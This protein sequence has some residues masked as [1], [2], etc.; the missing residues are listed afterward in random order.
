[1]GSG[2][3]FHVSAHGFFPAQQ[4]KKEPTACG[5]P[6]AL[7]R[8]VPSMSVSIATPLLLGTS[9]VQYRCVN[10]CK[11]KRHVSIDASPVPL[12]KFPTTALYP[13]PMAAETEEALSVSD[14]KSTLSCS[15]G[16][17]VCRQNEGNEHAK[18]QRNDRTKNGEVQDKIS[19]FCVIRRRS[20]TQSRR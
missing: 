10:F 14:V 17:A 5:Q 2:F 16:L 4:R 11:H 7:L 15:L 9:D 13:Y 12:R 8:P 19:R 3:S 18:A 6:R 20:T 1:M